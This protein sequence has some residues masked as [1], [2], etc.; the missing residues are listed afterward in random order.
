MEV[1]EEERRKRGDFFCVTENF[2][3]IFS[4]DLAGLESSGQIAYS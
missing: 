3:Q 4:Q 2:V 1:E